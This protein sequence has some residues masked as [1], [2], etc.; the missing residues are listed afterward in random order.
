MDPDFLLEPANIFWLE[1]IREPILVLLGGFCAGLA[2]LFSTWYQLRHARTRRLRET[3]GEQ[4][5]EVYKKALSRIGQLKSVLIQGIYEDAIEFINGH[6][7]WF[8]DNMILLPHTYV[9]NWE[10]IKSNL[11]SGKRKRQAM[12]TM[13]DG[14][15]RDRFIEELAE[16]DSFMDKLAGDAEGELRR[17]LRLPQ[18]TIK[19]PPKKPKSNPDERNT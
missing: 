16:L 1:E 2:G 4:Q 18:I 19:R 13:R 14:A 8:Y 11:R 10:S 6:E 5:L 12:E 3:I 9:E 17:E 15:D 7:E